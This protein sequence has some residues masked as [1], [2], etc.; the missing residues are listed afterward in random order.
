MR[1]EFNEFFFDGNDEERNGE[2][3]INGNQTQKTEEEKLYDR[4]SAEH[5]KD[6]ARLADVITIQIKNSEFR[7]LPVAG[8]TLT[9][10]FQILLVIIREHLEHQKP[11]DEELLAE[12]KKQID[13]LAHG[14]ALEI[15]DP[16]FR[17]LFVKKIDLATT[18]QGLLEVLIDLQKYL[19]YQT[20]KDEELPAEY[21][22]KAEW[23]ANWLALE[24]KDPEVRALFVKKV[25]LVA[26]TGQ[27]LIE[28]LIEVKVEGEELLAK[29]KKGTKRLADEINDP[30]L[31][32]LAIM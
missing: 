10:G 24:I 20:L 8:M 14:L 18:E 19:E 22:K 27:G 9:M 31:R 11:E 32:E 6:V 7:K 30:E 15:K 25:N 29:Y 4:L 5:E 1:D 28:A 13:R 23:L 3:M 17:E 16:E 21:K 2:G 12:Y 26:K